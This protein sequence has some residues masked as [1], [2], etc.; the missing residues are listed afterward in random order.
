MSLLNINANQT[1][2]S[3]V[4]VELKLHTHHDRRFC[5]E[6]VGKE[7]WAGP[8]S[9][10]I[11]MNVINEASP[12][13]KNRLCMCSCVCVCVGLCTFRKYLNHRQ[14]AFVAVFL[15]WRLF[16]PLQYTC[17]RTVIEIAIVRTVWHCVLLTCVEKG[18]WI[19]QLDSYSRFDCWSCCLIIT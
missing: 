4:K 9:N 12:E 8:Y 19:D 5:A 10:S 6:P 1:I 15:W 18:E 14:W 2:F 17:C 7:W 3:K 16:V 11:I 13:I